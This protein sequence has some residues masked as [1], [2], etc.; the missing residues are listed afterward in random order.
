MKVDLG[1]EE[2]MGDDNGAMSRL[3]R[4][5]RGGQAVF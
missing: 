3:V 4:Q 5:L 2:A 1:F